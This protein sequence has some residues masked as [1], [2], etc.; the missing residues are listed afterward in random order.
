MKI[1]WDNLE[2]IKLTKKGNFRDIVKGATYKLKVCPTCNEP[3]LSKGNTIFCTSNCIR[4]TE[5]TKINMSKSKQ[6]KNHHFYGK[7]RPEHGEKISGENNGWYKKGYLQEGKNNPNYGKGEKIRGEL[8]YN[9]KGG[10]CKLNIPL[11]DTFAHQVDWCEEV[12]R[13]KEDRNILEVK[14]A[15]CGKWY[16]PTMI[17]VECRS[18]ALKGCYTSGSEFR[19]YC[20]DSCKEECPIF[21][22]RV[23]PKGFKIATSREV[24]PELRQMVLK[25]DGYK[26]TKCGSKKSLHCHHVEGI[27]WEPLES[28]DIDKCITVCKSCHEAI[29]KKEGCNYYEFRCNK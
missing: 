19:L 14:C 6:G 17:E 25:R 7:K 15:Y 12:R 28:A 21:R 13:N 18:R 16:M 9:W 27:R 4:H 23:Y 5:E 1:C 22:Q 2:N 8:H 26:C 20:S 3:F 24:Q 10:V 29:H 11:Y